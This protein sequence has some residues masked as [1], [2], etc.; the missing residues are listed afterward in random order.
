MFTLWTKRDSQVSSTI[1]GK[2]PILQ[3]TLF[4]YVSRNDT[5]NQATQEG[6]LNKWNFKDIS[7]GNDVFFFTAFFLG[8]GFTKINLERAWNY[9]GG[10]N[11][12]VSILSFHADRN[13]VLL[14]RFEISMIFIKHVKFSF[15]FN[16]HFFFRSTIFEISILW[17]CN[18]TKVFLRVKQILRVLQPYGE[19]AMPLNDQ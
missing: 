9:S 15:S 11:Q 1:F 13:A 10:C 19:T 12:Y 7:L 3:T 17:V 6:T 16:D 8:V 18:V 5:L 14:R 4:E 2:L